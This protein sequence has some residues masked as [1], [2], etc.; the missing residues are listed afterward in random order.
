MI[1]EMIRDKLKNI[2]YIYIYRLYNNKKAK[3]IE[4][5]SLYFDIIEKKIKCYKKTKAILFHLR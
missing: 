2:I 5:I 4:S 3:R 1:N